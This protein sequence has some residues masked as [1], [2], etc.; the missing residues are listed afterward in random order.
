MKNLRNSVRLLGRL[1]A[2]AELKSMKNDMKRVAFRIATTDRFKRD[3]EI[4]NET[5]WHSVV[6]F[7]K[8]MDMVHPYLRK[9]TQVLIEG[10]IVYRQWTGQDGVQRN[11]AEI[12]G[13]ELLLISA[14]NKNGTNG[15]AGKT[16]DNKSC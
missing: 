6:F 10:K 8:K 12:I 13:D 15:Y 5:Q 9:G 7:G 3:G 1:G 2:D 4:V 14:G 16:A 11:T